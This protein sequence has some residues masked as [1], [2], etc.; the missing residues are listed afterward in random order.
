MSV[1]IPAHIEGLGT[2]HP[3]VIIRGAIDIVNAADFAE[4][5]E[6]VAE[7]ADD[8]LTLDLR[9]M[10]YIDAAGLG[11]FVGIASQL[12]TTSHL[13]IRCPQPHVRDLLTI[14]GLD[15]VWSLEDEPTHSIAVQTL[16]HIGNEDCRTE[17]D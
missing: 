16:D 8:Y 9:L 17:G 13:V 11:V 3:E 2:L 12:P 10:P 7:L 15:R 6:P 14:T 4:W 5:I 1:C